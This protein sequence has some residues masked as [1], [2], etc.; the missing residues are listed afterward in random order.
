MR[1]I[2]SQ[3]IYF[4]LI[5]KLCLVFERIVNYAP[6][7]PCA[8]IDTNLTD[9]TFPPALLDE[10]SHFILLCEPRSASH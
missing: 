5:F 2:V 3:L 8:F 9:A 6:S 4:Y 10:L 7:E 1:E